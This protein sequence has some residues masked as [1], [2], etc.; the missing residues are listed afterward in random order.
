MENAL[1]AALSLAARAATGVAAGIVEA[2]EMT[3]VGSVSRIAVR[4]PTTTVLIAVRDCRQAV[5]VRIG[6]SVKF[7]LHSRI[8]FGC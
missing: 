5:R 6:N 3:A 1:R 8:E 7:E 4:T 2:A